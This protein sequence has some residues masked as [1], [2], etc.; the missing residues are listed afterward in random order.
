[1]NADNSFRGVFDRTCR[2]LLQMVMATDLSPK[3]VLSPNELKTTVNSS[4]MKGAPKQSTRSERQFKRLLR[5]KAS[6]SSPNSVTNNDVQES[7]CIEHET[8]SS[9][10]QPGALAVG[11][12]NHKSE[13]CQVTQL[14]QLLLLHLELI[15]QQ[16]EQLQMKDRELNQ[17]KID[18][19]QL[20]ARMH[21]ME[22]R[23]AVRKRSRNLSNS[24]QECT[25][26]KT[27]PLAPKSRRL[28]VE[29]MIRKKRV[30]T[31]FSVVMSSCMSN[32]LSYDTHMRTELLYLHNLPEGEKAKPT[33]NTTAPTADKDVVVPQWQVNVL[34]PSH[35]SGSKSARSSAR[36]VPLTSED[37]P[38]NIEDDAFIKRHIKQELEEKRRKRWDVQRFRELQQH[39]SLEER[40]RMREEARLKGRKSLSK[41]CTDS[42][43]QTVSPSV[44]EKSL[45]Y[46]GSV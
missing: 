2:R 3:G 11:E 40:N 16:Q 33:L 1:M 38:E 43:Q 23:M 41:D 22:R 5:S 29:Q 4:D 35:P 31:S 18:K 19:E 9:V 37:Q 12:P 15:Q 26:E 39:K 24:D 28:S 44:E 46:L 30:P 6:N 10:R 17:L 36:N 8:D 14:R 20:E 21:R 45:I 13:P 25:E 42:E 32:D 27:K 34:Q 7:N